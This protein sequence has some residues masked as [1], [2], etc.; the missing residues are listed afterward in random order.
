MKTETN[1]YLQLL[2]AQKLGLPPES[3]T[4]IAVS[5][6]DV[7]VAVIEFSGWST[8]PMA[9]FMAIVNAADKLWKKD[10]Q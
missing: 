6:D 4:D 10:E 8:L 2:V 9:E 1:P 3:I 7:G 5:S